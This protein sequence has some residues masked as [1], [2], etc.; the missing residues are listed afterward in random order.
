MVEQTILFT[1]MPRGLN[2]NSPSL[3]VSVLVSPRLSG[4]DKLGDYP[5]WLNWTRDLKKNG[6]TLTLRCGSK[7]RKMRID[8]SSLRPELWRAMFNKDTYVKSY[9]FKDYTSRTIFSYPARLA[10]STLKSTYQVGGL[11]LGLPDRNPAKEERDSGYRQVVKQILSGFAVNWN[12]DMGEGLRK[13][14][15]AGFAQLGASTASSEAWVPPHYDPTWLAADGSLSI[16]PPAGTPGN[17]AVQK[18]VS[19]Q[20]SVYSHMPQGA[21]IQDNPPDFNT[22]IDFH[23][24][25]SSLNSYPELLRA[26]G[27]VFDLDLPA[28]FVAPTPVNQ[29]GEMSVVD[30]PGHAW[31]ITTHCVPDLAPMATAYLNFAVGDPDSPLMIFTT[32][33]ALLGGVLSD[34][35]IFGLLNLDPTR[36]G[37]AQVDLES[38]MNKSMLLAE[39]WSAGRPG[40]QPSDHP[41]VFDESATLPSLRSGGLS[42]FADGRAL[43]L[44]KTLQEN[45]EFNQDLE[46]S[47]PPKR[48]FYAEDL[49]H[50]YRLDIWDSQ[51]GQWH[52]LHRRSAVYQIGDQTFKPPEEVEGF[53]Q[54]AAG[55]AA[56][57]PQ[58]PPPDDLYLNESI[59]RWTGWSLSAP[60]PGKALSRDPDPDKAL[61]DDPNHP[62]NEPATPFKMTTQFSAT[63]KS[64]P[65]LRFGRRYRLRL[66]AVDLCGNSMRW[67]DPLAALLALLAGLPRDAQGFPYLRYEPVAA[68]QVVLRD[69]AGVTG[70]GSQLERLVIRTFNDDETKDDLPAD[71][72]ASDRFIAPPSTS[73]EVG[74]RMGMFD[75]AQGKLISSQAM[76]DLIGQR[77]QGRFNQ[78]QVQVAGQMKEFPLESGQTIDVL[79][80]LPD[81][82]ARGV[83]L[84]DLPGA[85]EFSVGEVE[86]GNG[87]AAPVGYNP[88]V[89]AN[90]RPG[91]ATLVSF[92]G[93]GDWQKLLPFRLALADG[94]Q[95]PSW[96]PQKRVLTVSLPKATQVLVPVSSYLLPD[97]LKLMGI[98]QWLREAIDLSVLL[99]PDVPPLDP[100][101]DAERI[102]H[103]LQRAVEGGH[104]MITPPRMLNLVHAVQ[105][106]LGRPA[107]TAL[108]VQ[109]Q[110]YGSKDPWGVVD[111]KLN[112]DPNVLQT[113]PEAAPTAGGE[114]APISAWRKPGAPEAYLLGG[115][116]IH[117][118]ST[119]KIDLLAEWK[120]PIDDPAQDRQPGQDYEQINTVQADEIPIP[121]TN[122]GYIIT[123]SGTPNYRRLAYYDAD[124]DLLCFVRDG[125]ELGNLK[126]GEVIYGDSAPRHYFNDT[127]YHRVRYT[128]QATSRFREYFDQDL[129]FTRK[130]EPVWVDVP[131]SARPVAPRLDYIVPTFGWQR[132]SQTNLKRS[133]RFSGG[134]RVYLERPWFSSGAGELLGAVLYDNRNGPLGDRELWKA[135]ITQ[136]GADPIWIAPGLSQLPYNYNFPNAAATEED[137]S[138]PGNV[139][140]RVAV[141]GFQ[142]DYDYERQKWFADINVDFYSQAYT[143]FIRL[144]L[145]RYQPCALPDSKLSAAVL[146]DYAQLTPERA[147]VVT[148]DPYHPRL[149]RFTVSGPA[150]SG[151][152]PAIVGS[153]PTHPV[154]V[155]TL[156]EVSLQQRNPAVQSDLG[157]Q[158]V[159][160]ATAAITPLTIP[161]PTG[162]IRWTGTVQFSSLPAAGQ[163]RLLVREY[164]YLSANYT[165]LVSP[166]RGRRPQREQPRRLIYAEAIEIDSALIG[167]PSSN[168]GTVVQE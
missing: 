127:K 47:H 124:H 9:A 55:Q 118:A 90:P 72:S 81:V 28:N 11:L 161:N 2:L 71:L 147:A 149:L 98:W 134:L 66:R 88:L 117:A 102:A 158:D 162:L 122:E 60:F 38:G 107:F 25:L 46:A 29:P 76:Y 121:S 120:D 83:A 111:E 136:W 163:Y 141:A 51:S 144:A 143:P 75:D 77:D 87:P 1:L 157:W 150:P 128:A 95:A 116:Q 166:A 142:V 167:G 92:D 73:V 32:A 165:N 139:P 155:P 35:E 80:Y 78:V 140:G 23:Q 6:L 7:T 131:A 86:P 10:L 100:E 12:E 26:L 31:Q 110:P 39:A 146:A 103:L 129:V 132:Q 160:A 105:Q 41:E 68:P 93:Q 33:P 152:P 13:S 137:L 145:V 45:K 82:L 50:G 91:S 168:F 17:A 74:E 18:F 20:F 24:A 138:L 108:T 59:T 85:T 67:D 164:E 57:D 130:S 126:S 96:D 114:L 4:S 84:R 16:L 15:R 19:Q 5:D 94:S 3:P 109:H 69:V 8:T 37:M 133:I 21:P 148:A 52:S 53:L 56:P 27:L 43:R 104:W 63:P 106:P 154:H 49:V 14:Y 36:F 44:L 99:V 125:D 30:V 64:L 97:D 70:P 42:V 153:Q 151:P 54:L 65:S 113:A 22:M 156:V 101:L 135:Y 112:P 58:N 115:L 40:P 89:D 119:E 79:P 48:P 61:V 34:L 123:G 159:P 62:Q